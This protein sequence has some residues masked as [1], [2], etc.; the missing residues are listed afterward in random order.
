MLLLSSLFI[1]VKTFLL[2]LEGWAA[3]KVRLVVRW[4]VTEVTCTWASFCW[5]FVSVWVCCPWLCCL[6]L[7]MWTDADYSVQVC[8]CVH[9]FSSTSTCG[10]VTLLCVLHVSGSMVFMQCCFPVCI[11]L[12]I[13]VHVMLW[14][15]QPY[16]CPG[17]V[18]GMCPGDL[19]R[20]RYS[21]LMSNWSLGLFYQ[22]SYMHLL[23]SLC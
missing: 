23:H 8:N 21:R 17:L 11:G 6:F 10:H 4:F 3:V 9:G 7:L 1:K 2:G 18:H 5:V 16:V 15:V 13:N 22:A 12:V 19:L 14:I 20:T